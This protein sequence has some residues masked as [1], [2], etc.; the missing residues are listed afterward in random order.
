MLEFLYGTKHVLLPPLTTPTGK[1][2]V[3]QARQ[4]LSSYDQ[5]L[6]SHFDFLDCLQ[7]ANTEGE[8][9]GDLVTCILSGRRMG[10]SATS[11][12]L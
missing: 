4:M 6:L 12:S 3:L 9:L 1:N 7:F 10:G 8:G 5:D 2:N 11:L